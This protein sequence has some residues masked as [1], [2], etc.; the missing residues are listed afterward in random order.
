[1]RPTRLELSGF[2]SFRERTVVEFE[3]SDYFALVGPTGSGK[4]SLIDAIC[5]ALYGSV[6]RYDHKGLVAPVVSQGKLEAKVRHDFVVNGENYTAVRVVRR[7]DKGATVKEAR[8]EKEGAEEPLAGT[9]PEL[10]AAATRLLGLS[11]EHF[12]KC[13]V[14]PQGDFARFLHDDPKDRQEFLVKLLNLGVYEWMQQAANTRARVAKDRIASLE[15]RLADTA[16]WATPETLKE[17]KSSVTR[18]EKLRKDASDAQPAIDTFNKQIVTAGATI[19]DATGWLDAIEELEMPD[20]TA[21]LSDQMTAAEKLLTEADAAVVEARG[22]VVA[23]MEAHKELPARQPLDAALAAYGRKG[24]LEAKIAGA[25]E[26]AEKANAGEATAVAER[27][28]SEAAL[29]E[30][31]AERDTARTN[32]QAQHL[33]G[34]LVKGE[35][36]PVCLQTVDTLPRHKVPQDLKTAEQAATKAA[37][38]H[39]QKRSAAEKAGVAAV[40]ARSA[41]AQIIEQY[42]EVEAALAD[43]PDPAAVEAALLQIENAEKSLAKL[44]T[45]EAESLDEAQV[46]RKVVEALKESAGTARAEFESARDSLAPLKPPAA[47]RKDLAEDWEKLLTWAEGQKAPLTKKVADAQKEIAAAEKG[48]DRLIETLEKTC[49]DCEVQVVDGRVLEAVVAAHTSAQREVVD[50]EGAI[51]AAAKARTELKELTLEQETAHQLA[52]HLKARAGGFVSWIVNEALRRLVEGATEILRELSN[53]QY[54]LTIDDVGTFQIT[55]R[56]N[57]GETRSARTLSGGETFLASL[58][59]A[60]A[61]A[62]QLAELATGGAAHLD[63]IFLDEGFGTLDPET[64]ETVA[65]TVENLAAG[66]RMVGIVTHVRELAD[67]VPVQFRVKKDPKTSTVERVA[68]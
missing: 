19:D 67:R 38:V 9:G 40:A 10:T 65:A 45:A 60:L 64:L 31:E 55:D 18:L 63:A 14:L 41:L 5:F 53:D 1:M 35:P 24:K 52:Q 61:L 33:A 23:A 68:S 47:E 8:L 28:R 22:K 66:G 42:E 46:A 7:T 13:V 4:S 29:A 48:R 25:T 34:H 27:T 62:D 39:E 15:E 20:D 12:T 30:A 54:A 51:A 26:T 21:A 16:D 17:A 37:T 58:S 36:C 59:L 50:I 11:F 2:T 44:R 43:H 49:A 6:P 56:N 32:H 3:G 57:A